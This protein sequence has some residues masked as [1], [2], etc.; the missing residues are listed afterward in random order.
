[1]IKRGKTMNNW[2]RE[3]RRW[4]TRG[5]DIIARFRK[6]RRQIAKDYGLNNVG[7]VIDNSGRHAYNVVICKDGTAELLEPQS[8]TW[9][10]PGESKMYS[11]KKGLILL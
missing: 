2:V 10:T 4:Q 8:D 9:V 6:S 1:M 7:I 3:G 5:Y 11:F